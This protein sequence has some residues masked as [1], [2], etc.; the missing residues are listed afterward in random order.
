MYKFGKIF[1]YIYIELNRIEL[2]IMYRVQ[3]A[4]K[5]LL[6]GDYQILSRNLY[7]QRGYTL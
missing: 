3:K 1:Q 4:N 5:C 2:K 6:K 7:L